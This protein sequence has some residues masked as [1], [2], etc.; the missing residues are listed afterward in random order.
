MEEG[1][2][3][4]WPV[5]LEIPVAWGDMDSLGHVNNIIYLRWFESA[6]IAYFERTG[7]IERLL[8]VGA[9]PIL[10]RQMI[11]YR[12]PVTYPD[13]VRVETTVS[14]LGNSSFV[15]G[16]RIHSLTHGTIAA[17][18]EGVGVMINYSTGEKVPID[19]L[20]RE[21]IYALEATPS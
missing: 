15:M 9:G 8:T 17:E 6:R 4:H 14:K 5:A 13:R 12:L 19:E 10:A 7:L 2:L 18:G 20:S 16:F 3:G 1:K 21:A 11:D